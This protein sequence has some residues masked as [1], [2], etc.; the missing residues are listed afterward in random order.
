MKF[1]IYYIKIYIK[2]FVNLIKISYFNC[3]KMCINKIKSLRNYNNI[4]Y[5]KYQIFNNAKRFNEIRKLFSI[6][7]TF[8]K[9]SRIKFI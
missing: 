4:E 7:F 2:N 3:V 6:Y 9:F 1:T 5:I 8:I